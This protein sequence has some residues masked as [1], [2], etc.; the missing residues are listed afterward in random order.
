MSV[1]I[2]VLGSTSAGNSTIIWNNR[3]AIMVDCGFSPRYTCQNLEQ[4]GQCLSMLS[5]VLI[6][7]SH[8]D[9]VK[10]TMLNR[11]IKENIPL[12]CHKKVGFVLKRKFSP[13]KRAQVGSLL[14]TFHEEQFSIGSFSVQSFEVPHDSSGGCFGFNIFYSKGSSEKKISIATDLGFPDDDIL[15]R[16]IDSDAII[17]ESNHDPEMLEN[18]PRPPW[19]KK[20][21]QKTGHL[22]ND[23]CTDFLEKVLSHSKKKPQAIILAHISQECNTNSRAIL[24]MQAMLRRNNYPDIEIVETHKRKVNKCICI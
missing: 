18:S 9:H 4:N 10:E 1:S 24:C 16:F 22:S 20:R 19:L 12:Y 8:T 13:L 6:T 17:I 21:I 23:Q 3:D 5:G 2:Q 14:R 15:G 7:H 11:L